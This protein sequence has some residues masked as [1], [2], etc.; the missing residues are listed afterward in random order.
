MVLGNLNTV[1]DNT[2]VRHF[3]SFISWLGKSFELCQKNSGSL[4]SFEK[5]GIG[6]LSSFPRF[7]FRDILESGEH[8]SH[9]L[10]SG[11][12]LAWRAGL[13]RRSS[14]IQ[15][16]HL[17]NE[18]KEHIT[19]RFQEKKVPCPVIRRNENE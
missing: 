11:M 3:L 19:I 8:E 6:C 5:L 16:F 17:E 4:Q 14:S 12:H 1:S 9:D 10:G 13:I 15:L 18:S 7:G 2:T